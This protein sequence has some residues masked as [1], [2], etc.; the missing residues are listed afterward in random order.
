MIKGPSRKVVLFLHEQYIMAYSR[1][2]AEDLIEAVFDDDIELDND[3]DSD[4][5]WW[6]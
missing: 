6:W 3:K 5:M 1:V 4:S 2:L